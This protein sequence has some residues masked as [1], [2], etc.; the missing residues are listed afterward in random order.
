MF[1]IRLPLA[2][3][4]TLLIAGCGGAGGGGDGA[5]GASGS[6]TTPGSGMTA[7]PPEGTLLQSP[8]Q[9]VS[10]MT[11]PSLL[12]ELMSSMPVT[13]P[14][15]RSSGAATEVAMVSA[16]APGREAETWIIGKSTLGISSTGSDR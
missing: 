3:A 14:R 4:A 9:L 2:V 6:G 16:L 5:A 8:A 7:T 10:T 15:W 12:V 13:S 11:A 1:G